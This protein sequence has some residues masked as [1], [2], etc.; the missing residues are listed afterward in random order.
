MKLLKIILLTFSVS[1]LFTGSLNA[2]FLKK[3]QKSVEKG[4]EKAVLKKTE[5]VAADK[6]EQGIDKLLNMEFMKMYDEKLK[7]G[8]AVDPSVLPDQ[9]DFEWKYTMKIE[10]TQ[11]SINM[12]YYLT[13]NAEYFGMKPDFT[14]QKVSGNMIIVMDV[15]RNVTT[16]FMDMG[17]KKI[18]MPTAIPLDIE[19]EET[20][21][22]TAGEYV[23]E[24]IGT[25][26]ILGKTCQ[27]FRMENEEMKVIIYSML[28]A[29]IS[30]N[31]IF[32]SDSQKMP[33]GFDPKWLKKME[34]S[35]VMEMTYTDKEKSL[36]ATKMECVALSEE[37]F[38]VSKSDYEFMNFNM[39][40]S[41]TK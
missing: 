37:T 9:Y 26:E 22:D 7:T 36:N 5:E 17:D 32:G 15:E 41:E 38:A 19:L 40:V 30:F 28:D 16:M 18:A 35:L 2:Q 31:Q 20:D 34:N 4:V 29:P 24:E 8:K 11:G 39:P 13:P 23:F 25:K 12:D 14:D 27:G 10:T 21:L 1:I 33:K 6:T 3:L